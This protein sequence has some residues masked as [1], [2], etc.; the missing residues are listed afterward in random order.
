VKQLVIRSAS[1]LAALAIMGLALVPL[2]EA[3]SDRQA[4][5]AATTVQVKGGEFFFKLSTKSVA[6]PRKV[7]FVFKNIGHVLHDFKINGKKT[8]L[9]APGKTATLAVTLKK[10][11]YTYLCTVPGHAAAGMKGVFTVH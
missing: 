2:A 11:K 9:I 10:G 4:R 7:T 6:T 3:Q 8:P 5:S 1:A